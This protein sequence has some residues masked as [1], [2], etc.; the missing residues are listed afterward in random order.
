MTSEWA[1]VRDGAKGIP[2]ASGEAGTTAGIDLV[3]G[4]NVLAS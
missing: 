1:R 4:T 2:W 3:A